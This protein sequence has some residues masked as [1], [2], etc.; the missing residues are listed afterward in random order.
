MA[1]ASCCIATLMVH[2]SP[3]N[4]AGTGDAGGMNIYLCEAA[5]NMAAIG[6]QVGLQGN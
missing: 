6:V 2:I 5:Q 1:M 3:L 4:Q